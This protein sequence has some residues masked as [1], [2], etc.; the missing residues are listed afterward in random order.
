M[1]KAIIT[2]GATTTHGGL[3][4]EC[5]TTVKIFGEYAHVEGMS[6]YCPQCNIQSYA[7]GSDHSKNFFGKT[8]ILEGDISTCGA[9][10]IP[11]QNNAFANNNQKQLTINKKLSIVNNHSEVRKKYHKQFQLIDENTNIPLSKVVYRF[12]HDQEIIYQGLSSKEGYTCIVES[13]EPLIIEVQVLELE[14]NFHLAN[15]EK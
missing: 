6:H 5:L 10:F 1:N 15:S 13:N 14:Q 7:I 9:V 12:L 2:S 8:I 4:T 3:I 11:K